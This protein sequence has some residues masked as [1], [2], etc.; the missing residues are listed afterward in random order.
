M[1]KWV[2]ELSKFGIKYQ[3]RT[4]LKVWVLVSLLAEMTLDTPTKPTDLL[5]TIHA[6][7]SSNNKVSGARLI[8]ENYDMG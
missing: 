6:D 7:G 2:I 5:W 4:P 1:D 8:V 3:E